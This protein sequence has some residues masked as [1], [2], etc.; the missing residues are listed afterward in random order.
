MRRL[1]QKREHL[2]FWDR[3]L[4][5]KNLPGEISLQGDRM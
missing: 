2:P 5:G 3:R 4:T 1:R